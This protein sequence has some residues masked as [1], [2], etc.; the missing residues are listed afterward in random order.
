MDA[1]PPPPLAE[2]TK[3]M[4]RHDVDWLRVILFGLLIWFHYA[5]FSLDALE[6]GDS[7]MELFNLPLFFIIAVMHQ[8]RL[9]AL[10]VISGMGTAF[11]FRRRTWSVYVKERFSRLG[12]PLLFGTYILFFGIFDPLGTTARLFEL[13]P[14]SERM[15]YGHLWFIYNLLIY[16]VLLT[17]LFSHVR[18]NPNGKIVQATRSLLN[19]R[20]NLGLLLLPPL[21][22]AV[23][24]IVFKPWGFGEVG[25]WW[26]FPRFMLYFLFGYLMITA[27]EDY[28]PAIDRVRIPVTVITPVLALVWFVSSEMFTTPHVYDGGW[29][30]EGYNAF[31][32]E[33]TIA[34]LI[35]S[36]HAWFWCLFVFSWASKL[37][38]K[39]S[40][41][42]AYL[43]EAVYPTYIVH[44][45]LTFLPI[46]LLALIGLGYY[47]SMIIG[48]LV[49]F[50]GVM[51]CFEI[52]RRASL[53]R[54][55]F[56][57]KGGKEEVNKLYPYTTTEE[58][59]IRFVISL[60]FNALAVGMI[61]MLL[62]WIIGA[63]VLSA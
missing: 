31:A 50:V 22:L 41:R 11:A 21:I 4:R 18:N 51:I 37:L 56:G 8:W 40:K 3:P 17:P 29:V 34:A 53:F 47:T 12:I 23:S 38:N 33:T 30:A 5:V 19:A 43:N 6:G 16:S 24:N 39:P 1:S 36:F 49:V 27:K 25:M 48:T 14:G 63:D 44:M 54:P 58:K 59:G 62:V 61:L 26:E 42:L 15:P 28:F 55:L 20:R 13:F 52:A 57:I 10:F 2:P 9:A 46:A 45:H 35:Q 60:V 7:N 32:L